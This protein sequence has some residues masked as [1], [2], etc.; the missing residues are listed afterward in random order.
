MQRALMW[1]NLL[2]GCETVQCKLKN[3]Q[4]CIFCVFRQFVSL[5][6][7]KYWDLGGFENLSFFESAILEKKNSKKISFCWFSFIHSKI[8]QTVLGRNFDDYNCF[9]PKKHL[10]KHMQQSNSVTPSK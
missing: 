5:S 2:Y 3:R 9:Q 7:K 6:L 4:E 8:S 1:P 10:G